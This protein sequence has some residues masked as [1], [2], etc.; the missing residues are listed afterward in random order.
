MLRAKCHCVSQNREER[1]QGRLVSWS[2]REVRE[3][4]TLGRNIHPIQER[5]LLAI[6][7]KNEE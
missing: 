2:T 4:L 3:S 5:E 1:Y 6:L 7:G